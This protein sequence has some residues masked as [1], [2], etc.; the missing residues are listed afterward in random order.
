MLDKFYYEN[1]FNETLLFGEGGVI[2]D[3]NE[4]RDYEWS[5]DVMNGAIT[6]F[7]REP[8]EKPMPITFI[9]PSE[10]YIKTVRNRAFKIFEKDAISRKKGKLHI[11]EYYLNCYIIGAAN[12]NYLSDGRYLETTFKVITDDP[13]W[14]KEKTYMFTQIMEHV[15]GED[16]PMDFPFDFGYASDES[17]QVIE[18]DCI[19]SS[20]FKLNIYGPC[21]DPSIE[22]NGHIYRVNGIIAENEFIEIVADKN[23]DTR[24]I[25]KKAIGDNSEVNWFGHRYKEQSVFEEIP[26]GKIRVNW[27]GS[28]G[29]NLTLIEARSEPPWTYEEKDKDDQT[30]YSK[31]LIDSYDN[32]ILDSDSNYIILEG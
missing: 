21:T 19:V 25:I 11:G 32:Y 26:E 7:T 18:N 8:W 9:G 1:N 27:D 20:P 15:G 4:L 2:A 31:L 24:T 17:T 6:G 16:P 23:R 12:K 30:N 5:Y 14:H 10:K 28:F 3:E 22:I 13:S 29:F